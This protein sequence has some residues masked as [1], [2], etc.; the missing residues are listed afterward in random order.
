MTFD[1]QN[2]S[3]G[4]QVPALTRRELREREAAA[5]VRT[6]RLRPAG[7]PQPE[8]GPAAVTPSSP[9]AFDW[10]FVSATPPVVPAAEPVVSAGLR[11]AA[12]VVPVVPGEPSAIDALSLAAAAVVD[13][14]TAASGA[15]LAEPSAAP[16]L[17]EVPT[18][19]ATAISIKP[20][21]GIRAARIGRA[22]PP[23][24]P[25]ARRQRGVRG[26]FVSKALSFGAMVFAAALMV[27][28]SVPATLFAPDGHNA[29][30]YADTA[31]A[32]LASV[33]PQTLAV[34][35]DAVIAAP[36]REE[37]TV[38]S[39]AEQLRQKY[40]ARSYSF[41]ATSGA[42]RWPFPYGVTITD[43]YGERVSPC[44]GC[45]TFHKGVDFTPGAGTPIYAIADGVVSYVEVSDSGLG[46]HVYIDHMVNGQKVTSIYAHMQMNSSPLVLGEV[47]P[48]GGFIGLVG[49]TGAS[50]GAHLHL[51]IRV[52]GES[53]DPFSWL[54][55]N[56]SN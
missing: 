42:V 19:R 17:A 3:E 4:T 22:R 38:T 24:Q 10:S 45:S 2:V 26:T 23:R 54:Q 1:G 9:S 33:V 6:D 15:A 46:N 36:I 44:G 52:N 18:E 25:R 37:Y 13:G 12:Q 53:V 11:P 29:L 35:G 14:G 34:A 30:A 5:A 21:R 27:G 39:Y 55:A 16:A 48:V 40:T 56:A 41:A 31:P 50:V 49:N 28:M 43:G 47:V 32:P 8:V 20:V 7:Q 51:E